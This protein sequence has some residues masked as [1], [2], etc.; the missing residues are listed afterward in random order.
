[1][2]FSVN[3]NVGALTALQYLSATQSQL[4]VTQSAIN[5]GL[6]VASARDDGSI[7]AIAQNQR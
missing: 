3:T 2:T 6:K 7:F 4:A 1:M 5:S